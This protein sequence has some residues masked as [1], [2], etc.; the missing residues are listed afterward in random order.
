MVMHFVQDDGGRSKYFKGKA[1]DCVT[2]AISIASGVD[3]REVYDRLAAGN[4]LQRGGGKKSA[5]HGIFVK[6]KWFKEYM[7]ELGFVWTPTMK[8]GSGCTT[9]LRTGE[10]PAEG[11]LVCS[12]SKHYAA[13]I[14]GVI[15]DTSDPSRNGRRCVYGF[16]TLGENV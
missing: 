10:L 9:H 16:W 14:D 6:R 8:V 4:S 11:K 13:V 7:A 15:H 12:L 3:Y 2:R 5:R 1:G